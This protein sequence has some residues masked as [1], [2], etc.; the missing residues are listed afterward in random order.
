MPKYFF[1]QKEINFLFKH[2]FG[3]VVE[4]SIKVLKINK[5]DFYLLFHIIFILSSSSF[6]ANLIF[7]PTKLSISFWDFF[8][9][10][11][12]LS[13]F[14]SWWMNGKFLHSQNLTQ[15][16][17]LENN[18]KRDEGQIKNFTLLFSFA[19]WFWFENRNKEKA[20]FPKAVDGF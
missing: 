9:F 1:K 6:K 19:N 18:R 12:Y 7:F 5:I 3:G 14:Q 10:S 16:L 4:N 13:Y 8:V 15:D 20:M 2:I 11:P 17:S